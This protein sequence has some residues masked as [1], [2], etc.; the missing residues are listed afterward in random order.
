MVVPRPWITA[1]IIRI[2]CERSRSNMRLE[3]ELFLSNVLT[4]SKIIVAHRG[5][6]HATQ[7][8]VQ[9]LSTYRGLYTLSYTSQ[10][11]SVSSEEQLLLAFERFKE[12][13]FGSDV[14]SLREIIA[15]EYQGFDP[16][17][18]SQDRKMILEA[19]RPGGVKLDRYDVEDL[20]V[21]IVGDVGIITGKGCIQGTYADHEFGHHVRFMDLYVRRDGGWLLYLSQVTPLGA[22]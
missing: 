19:Y 8:A 4:R 9:S 2:R 12:A 15:E 1:G 14:E 10:G 6:H 22:V 3:R 11:V 16:Q 18:Q 5:K 20:E 7:Q 21:R 17:G 13:L